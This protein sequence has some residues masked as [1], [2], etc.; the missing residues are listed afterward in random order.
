MQGDGM[1]LGRAVEIVVPILENVSSAVQKFA[2]GD[3]AKVSGLVA[4]RRPQLVHPAAALANI[5]DH[6]CRGAVL[7]SAERS[8]ALKKIES[9]A[10]DLG[11]QAP[12]VDEVLE[13]TQCQGKFEAVRSLQC[14]PFNLW[15]SVLPDT[16]LSSMARLFS[17]LPSSQA[18]TERVFSAADWAVC[19]RER[20]GFEKLAIEV[21]L[22]FNYLRLREGGW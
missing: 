18:S 10:V 5:F 13:F 7:S 19:N 16:G 15:S 8:E 12:S 3:V 6:N 14:A 21:E 4:E 2:P 11:V 9:F 22:R 20:L 1:S 17:V